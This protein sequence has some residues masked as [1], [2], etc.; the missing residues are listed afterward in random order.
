MA[1]VSKEEYVTCLIF[2]MA[3]VF[4]AK[5]KKE[6]KR[7]LS[8]RSVAYPARLSIY[9][10]PV[11]NDCAIESL[12]LRITLLIYSSLAKLQLVILSFSQ[13]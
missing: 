11:K 3:C 13:T 1:L 8:V 9:V 12:W 7:E 10:L 5:K 4:C 2:L 6:K